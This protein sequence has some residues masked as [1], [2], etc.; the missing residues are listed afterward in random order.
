MNPLKLA[1]LT[2]TFGCLVATAPF[3]VR[4]VVPSSGGAAATTQAARLQT[5][6]TPSVQTAAGTKIDNSIKPVVHDV[7]DLPAPKAAPVAAAVVTA[8]AP[9]ATP[10][11][12]LA[13]NP[14]VAKAQELLTKLGHNV[15][16]VDGK[17][18]QR[19]EM[20]LIA[21]QKKNNLKADGEANK[22]TLALLEKQVADLSAPKTPEAKPEVVIAAATAP[23]KP[24]D[25]TA[26]VAPAAEPQFVVLKNEPKTVAAVPVDPGPVPTLRRMSDVQKL[27]ER[28]LVAGTYTGAADGKWGQL[29][30]DAM[31][32][33]Q[34][35]SGLKVTG[36]PNKETWAKLNEAPAGSLKAPEAV[37][38]A[39]AAAKSPKGAE[40]VALPPRKAQ[41]EPTFVE[42]GSQEQPV[43]SLSAKG[44]ADAGPA[45]AAVASAPSGLAIGADQEIRSLISKS[46]DAMPPTVVAS[47]APT[48]VKETETEKRVLGISKETKLPELPKSEPAPVLAG[49]ISGGKATNQ[50]V[51]VRVNVDQGS[52]S[53]ADIPSP[54]SVSSELVSQEPKTVAKAETPAAVPASEAKIVVDPPAAKVAEIPPAEPKQVA[55]AVNPILNIDVPSD[56]VTAQGGNKGKNTVAAPK[57]RAMEQKIA[58][59]EARIA[60]VANDERYELAKYSPKGLEQVTLLVGQMRKQV[61]HQGGDSEALARMLKQADT[62]LEKAKSDSLKMKASNKVKEV[63]TAYKALKAKYPNEVKQ[64]PLNGTMSKIDTGFTAMKT[65]FNKGNYDPI[66]ERCDGFKL[67]IEILTNDAAKLYVESQLAKKSVRAKLKKSVAKE[68][69]DLSKQ[70]KFTEAADLLTE[71]TSASSKKSS[72]GSK[73]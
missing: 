72:K 16:T 41:S 5:P 65:D 38:V 44:D 2:L 20:T 48:I 42:L 68:V 62:E 40:I 22:G 26:V 4:K 9:K 73:G 33:F 34:E 12:E 25:Q 19:T 37:F 43:P 11:P 39:Q 69:E 45:E 59:T 67:A 53:K 29:T 24:A 35:K 61:E 17:R 3:V 60:M 13:F 47:A 36:K 49:A 18:G 63:D 23:A 15:G 8:P 14:D 57:S 1:L 7:L 54:S 21:F 28:L 6:D 27:Q 51:V 70:N 58:E 46:G 52:A 71:N 32:A 31:K 50:Q 66:V 10:K 30:V 56:K 55:M 64:E